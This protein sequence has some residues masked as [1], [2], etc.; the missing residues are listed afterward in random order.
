MRRTLFRFSRYATVG[1]STFLFDLGM[2]SV[3]VSF[4]HVSYLIATP[5]AFLIAVSCNYAISRK[6][7]FGK[8]ERTWH[9]GY[10]YFALL[11]LSGAALTTGLVAG[12][13][14][15]F[16]LQYLIARSIVAGAIGMVNYLV[17]LYFNFKVAGKH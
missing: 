9:G 17:N 8:T 16:G 6:F 15:V 14:S 1:V 2:L 10:A 3:A 5:C 12:L 11:A 4:F 13:V 7:V